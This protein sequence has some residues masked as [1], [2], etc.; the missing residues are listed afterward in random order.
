MRNFYQL[1][2]AFVFVLLLC[3]MQV[4]AQSTQVAGR[5]TSDDS[6]SGL[7]G[8][9]IIEKG[10]S[11][12]TVT[13]ADGKYV[14][15]VADNATIVFSFV[16]YSSQEIPVGG[17]STIDVVLL[18]DVT[19]LSEVV[20]IG[21]GRADKKDVTGAITSLGENQLNKGP[22]VNPL[23]QL[24]GRA[25]GV[26]INQV[27]NEPGVAPSIRIRGITSLRGGNDPLVVV[28]GIQ[29][30][31]R[32]L[33][34]IPPSEIETFDILKDAS[35]TA[36]Y[37]S[38]GAAGVVLV[39]T[40]KGKEGRTTLEYSGV[41]S[42]D[43]I[44]K[45]LEMLSADEYRQAANARGLTDYDRGGNTN[46]MDEITR[47]GFTQTHNIAFGGGTD[48]LNYRASGTAILQE[49]VILNSGSNSFIGR[50]QASQKAI[51][52]KL[53]L[54]YNL[55]LSSITRE[56]N[57]P[58]A[59]GGALTTRPTNPIYNEDGTYF[60]DASLFNYTNPAA[61][62]K[63]IIDGNEENNL[64]G[65]MKAD[66]KL[67]DGLTASVFGSWRKTDRAYVNYQSRLATARGRE[68][69][70]SAE[71]TNERG[72]E[73]LFNFV[74]NYS[75]TFGDHKVEATGVYEWQKQ[76]YEG[77]RVAGEGF[78][79]DLLGADAIQNAATFR[80]GDVS[81]YK[82]DRTLVSFLG[83][84]N[85]TFKDRYVITGSIRR[86]GASV[87]GIN[88]KWANFPS[89]GLAWRASEESFLSDVDFLSTLKLR[90]GFGST[91]NQQGLGPLNSMRLVG[92]TGNTFFGGN[93]IRDFAIR[94]NANPNL[95][96]ETREM[97]N[98][99][100]DFGLFNEKINGTIE[101][102]TGETTD[103]LFDYVVPVPPFDFPSILANVGTMKNTGIEMT[104]NY[105]LIDNNDL[106]IDLGANVS[107]IKTEILNLSG[108]IPDAP[109]NT[110]YVAWGG[111][112]IIGVGGQNND[113]SYLI[114]GQPLG[115]FFLFKHAGIDEAGN[116]IIDDLNGNG[117]IESGRTSA[118]R[119]IT[120]Q[121]LPKV[122]LGFTPSIR[123]K[124]LE[125][126]LVF[127]GA[128]GHKIFN[129]RKA[130]LST[131]NRLGQSNVLREALATGM[132][133]VNEASASDYWL[134]DGSF[135]RL[136][137]LTLGYN[138]N[139]NNTKLFSMVKVS[140]TSNNLFVITDY[141]GIDPE[142]RNDGGSGAGLDTGIYPR[143]R[144]FAIGINATFK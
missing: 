79:N 42:M 108:S 4:F 77:G 104:L 94:Q 14:L 143:T 101:Y 84:L 51:D 33:N 5:V 53:S 69:G 99:G 141:S 31:L 17:K 135:T 73:R 119:H 117:S 76:I 82:S 23:Q 121:A 22:V 98:A 142:I 92:N 47:T 102:F 136:E 70:G 90:A 103:L 32:L 74:L 107:S 93:L 112:D 71:R 2:N 25:A 72:N 113:M 138:L 127:R 120:G 126:D 49:G 88:N 91:G 50:I 131:L 45:E 35:A 109:L 54:T 110:D 66:Y 75:K 10:T 12:G 97:Y 44:S 40:K 95:R 118:D 30:D 52:D 96:W 27:G 140:F 8:V 16:G 26:S 38:R 29:G 130:Q 78:P 134:E 56:F 137:N 43:V 133:N 59:V 128:Y 48:K 11:N 1:K 20:V 139:V 19:S 87:F 7:P 124:N 9:S 80:Q 115:T 58:G 3:S 41:F 85:Y 21:Y 55:N 132:Q 15:T 100:I 63:E 60:F 129:V 116:Q 83:R 46:W 111:A 125:L 67:F 89:V 106:S 64:F 123:Y 28:D 24:N 81:S 65:S 34:S 39:T 86:D 37:G 36:I 122:Y 13:D 61:R 68:V 114:E 105:R 6:Q 144:N 57:G 18:T 62:V